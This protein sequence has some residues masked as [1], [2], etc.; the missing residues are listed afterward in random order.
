MAGNASCSLE[1]HFLDVGQGD[2]VLVKY[3]NRSML[4]RGE[5]CVHI[6]FPEQLLPEG[7]KEGD[8]PDIEISRDEERTE[9]ARKQVSDLIEKLKRKNVD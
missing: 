3:G 5:E 8:I 9:E 7:C 1:V 2:S 4:V 6:D